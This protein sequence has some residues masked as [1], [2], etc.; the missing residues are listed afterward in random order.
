MGTELCIRRRSSEVL[1]F[2]QCMCHCSEY[3]SMSMIFY[4]TY[5]CHLFISVS[6]HLP[7]NNL[8]AGKEYSFIY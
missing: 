1:R 3:L 4:V 6:N 8:V 5:I 2:L 7:S